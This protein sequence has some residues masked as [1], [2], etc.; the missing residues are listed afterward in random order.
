L[1]GK[2]EKRGREAGFLGW[3]EAGKKQEIVTQQWVVFC[4]RK[5]AKRREPKKMGR[6]PGLKGRGNE[7]GQIDQ[8]KESHAL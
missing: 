7:N 8:Y 6:E 1:Y 4:N 3:P 2:R 5:T